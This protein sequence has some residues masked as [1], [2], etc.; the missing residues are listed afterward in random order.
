MLWFP[1]S[2]F[3]QVRQPSILSPV[4]EDTSKIW[5]TTGT[6]YCQSKPIGEQRRATRRSGRSPER[7]QALLPRQRPAIQSRARRMCGKPGVPP[8]LYPI[9]RVGTC[10]KQFPAYKD[11]CKRKSEPWSAPRDDSCIGFKEPIESRCQMGS[12]SIQILM[13]KANN[14]KA[15]S[16]KSN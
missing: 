12:V 8:D 1:Y 6:V 13:N 9:R 5:D 3:Q 2:S 10:S 7:W 16:I 4:E 15:A 14:C 11:T